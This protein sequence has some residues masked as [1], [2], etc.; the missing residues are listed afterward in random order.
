MDWISI[1]ADILIQAFRL[2]DGSKNYI[3]HCLR[4]LYEL[5][6][7]KGYYPSVIDLYLYVKAQKYP[8]QSRTARY[9]E[10]ILNRIGGLIYS[11][12]GPV[13]DC[14]RGHTLGIVNNH[15]IFEILFLTAEHQVLMVNYLMSY[16]Y[17]YKQFN[18]TCTKHLIALDDANILFDASYEKRPDI[19]LPIIHHLLTTVRKSNISIYAC[20]QTPHQIGSSIHSNSF[21]KIMFALSNGLDIEFMQKSMGII[22]P[23]QKAYCYKLMP[24]EVIV[25]FSSR[26][27]EPFPATVPEVPL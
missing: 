7:E 6:S 15:A 13:L 27:L 8:P 10:S 12:L 4:R 1:I 24:R 25:K 14:S 21:A 18:E 17:I 20:T 3:I 19:G 26:Y 16:L 5:F 9:Q 11:S 2:Y 22:D 23:A